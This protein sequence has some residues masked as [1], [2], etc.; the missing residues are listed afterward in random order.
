MS[1]LM[2]NMRP[3]VSS[4]ESEDILNNFVRSNLFPTMGATKVGPYWI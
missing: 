2:Q 3:H 1:M 4:N